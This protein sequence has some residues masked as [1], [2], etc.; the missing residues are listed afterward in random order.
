MYLTASK[1]NSE[2]ILTDW[3]GRSGKFIRTFGLNTKRNNNE[4]RVTWDSIKQHIN[5]A[6]GRPGIEY[7]KCQDDK[8]DLDHV[9][10]ESFDSLIR[11]QKPYERT[12]IVDYILNE[13]TET[14]DLIHEVHDKEFFEKIKDGDIQY[15]SAMVW[16]ATGGYDTFGIGRADQP[17]IDAY[18]WKFVHHAFLRDNPAYGRDIAKVQTT[19][20]GKDCQVQLLSA[21]QNTDLDP[22]KEIPLLYRHNDTLHLVSAPECV[23]SIIKKKK[24]AGIKIDDKVLS[25]AYSECDQSNNLKS[26]FKTCTCDDRQNKMDEDKMKE[27]ESKLKAQEEENKKLESK[28]KAQDE[29]KEKEMVSKK[30]RYSKLFAQAEDD[31]D[32]KKMYA[33]LQATTEDKKEL[34]AMHEEY[35]NHTKSKKS[36]DENPKIK[37]L[38]SRLKAKDD[39][40]IIPMIA[41]LVA[42]RKD[43]MPQ[44][45]LDAF[46]ISLKAKSFTEIETT[47]N[48]ELYVINALPAKEITQTQKFEFNGNGSNSHALLSKSLEEIAGEVS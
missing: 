21:S 46:E 36:A 34:E 8:C 7:E 12:K 18:H 44:T 20:E 32:S 4:W 6:I 16:P 11:K 5:T 13:E 37:E 40:E 41:S 19:C 10:A 2:H 31:E 17:I 38:E 3:K 33:R 24:D 1:I 26:S 43:K 29:D 22:L 9:D 42:V 45:E 39:K 28:L 30:S 27:L 47:F 23:Q 14:V 25:I 35:D 15:V 48:N